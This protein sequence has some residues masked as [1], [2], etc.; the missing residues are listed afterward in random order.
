MNKSLATG[1]EGHLTYLLEGRTVVSTYWDSKHH[2]ARKETLLNLALESASEGTDVVSDLFVF[3]D[4]VAAKI[5]AE[6]KFFP[7]P[8]VAMNY[9]NEIPFD[10]DPVPEEEQF[11][12]FDKILA[13]GM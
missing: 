1:K 7:Y 10:D 9:V 12:K 8:L 5:G 13:Y 11:D 3:D 4:V 2:K 6:F